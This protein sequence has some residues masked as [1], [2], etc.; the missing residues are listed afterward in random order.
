MSDWNAWMDR[1]LA[2]EPRLTAEEFRLG[3]ALGRMTLGFRTRSERFGDQL[4]RDT[5]LLHGRSLESA[6]VGLIAKGLLAFEKGERG[7]GKR[8]RYTLLL[9]EDEGLQE[10]TGHDRAFRF[11]HEKTGEK[12]GHGRAGIEEE[13]RGP[14][15]VITQETVMTSLTTSPGPP[16]P[17][18]QVP[19]ETPRA[20]ADEPGSER[21]PAAS[22][23]GSARELTRDELVLGGRAEQSERRS[24]VRIVDECWKCGKE[25][26]IDPDKPEGWVCDDCLLKERAGQPE[27]EATS[28]E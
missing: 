10:K 15:D 2:A 26:E 7:R 13:G 27:E 11:P 6:R 23:N 1:L 28:Q 18:Q 12:T 8:S 16:V 9:D 4:V 19:R 25:Y 14:N 3:V 24:D 21:A 20:R 17:H 5:A 22:P